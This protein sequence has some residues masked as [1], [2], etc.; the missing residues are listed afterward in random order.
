[1]PT[2]GGDWPTL[3]DVAK[4]S[5]KDGKIATIVEMLMQQNEI[6]MDA[7]FYEGNL[8]TGHQVTQRT[9][10]PAVYYRRINQGVP[11]SKSTTA[12]IIVTAANLEALSQIDERLAKLNGIQSAWAMSEELSFVEAMNQQVAATTFYGSEVSV[13]EEFTGLA[14]Q[15]SSL[16]ANSG[17]NI[18][19]AG[20]SGTDNASLWL[21]TWGP[22]AS[23]MFYPKG[24]TGS[25]SQT[26]KGLI[27]VTDSAG[28]Y[29]A[30]TSQWLWQLGM[31]V[32]DWQSNV[33][34]A[35]ID[36]SNLV[37]ESSAADIL[38]LM[39]KAVHKIPKR[40][41]G[42]QVFYANRTLMAMLDIQAQQKS[43]VYLTVG[44]EEGRPKVSFRGIPIRS[45]DQLLEN[46]SRVT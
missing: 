46:E 3:L 17:E 5:D 39:T 1:M 6:L 15:Y 13:P 35:N 32:A 2:I 10:L 31:C 44:N 34:I 45:V 30:W 8:P 20:G 42:R 9:G 14:I 25:L 26:D 29:F 27:P 16:T 40:I 23:Y 7:P 4:R 18:I 21:I 38:K 12:Q 43:N 28:T 41:T 33:R 37:G 11:R 22:Q 19:D 24:A 36:V